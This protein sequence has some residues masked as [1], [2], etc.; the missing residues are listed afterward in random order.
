MKLLGSIV[1]FTA[2][3]IGY[4]LFTGQVMLYHVVTGSMEPSIPIGSLVVA[5]PDKSVSSGDV[6]VYRLGEATLLHRVVEVLPTAI[7]VM[8][9]ASSNYVEY[10]ELDRVVGRMI[11]A[12]PLL[13]YVNMMPVL[14]L[15]SLIVVLS[16]FGRGSGVGF[17]TSAASVTAMAILGDS[18]L[19]ILG[20]PFAVGFLAGLTIASRIAEV[21]VPEDK[22]WIEIAYTCVFLVSLLSISPSGL[23]RLTPL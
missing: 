8:A 6:M 3:I 11:L 22:K 10:V 7:K 14:A 20:K 4:V 23:R 13:G 21:R 12:I 1:V 16:V 2:F 9:D 17:W 18:G 15:T 5:V 19:A